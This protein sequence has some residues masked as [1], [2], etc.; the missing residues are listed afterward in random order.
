MHQVYHN[1]SFDMSYKAHKRALKKYKKKSTLTSPDKSETPLMKIHE[2]Q[3]VI[4]RNK[5]T[6]EIVD[7]EV[8]F[9]T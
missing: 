4:I 3:L 9:A 8:G 1:K 7:I 5:Q 6:K 2:P